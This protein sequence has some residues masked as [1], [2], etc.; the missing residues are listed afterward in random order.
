MMEQTIS[1]LEQRVL[2][3]LI[4]KEM[5]TPDYYPLTLNSM[6]L[7]CN[8]KS[9]RDPVVD[10]SEAEVMDGFDRLHRLGL[11]MPAA[12]GS[13]R[14]PKFRH[15]LAEELHLEIEYLALL[16]TLL[17]RGGQTTGELRNRT[18]RM[19][20]FEDLSSVESALDDLV[21]RDP[22]LVKKL[23]RQ[24]GRKECRY[25]HLFGGET[26]GAQAEPAVDPQ[27]RDGRLEALEREVAQLREE[28]SA[29]KS[30]LKDLL[31]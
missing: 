6:T 21:Q 8:Q 29:L 14:V 30:Q 18:E 3:V 1:P 2:G 9:N 20:A 19:H 25:I 16:C 7:A 13:G 5:A 10:F 17:L 22:P 12:S 31:E 15:C 23:E 27:S 24:P 11:A 28:L 4:E 26:E